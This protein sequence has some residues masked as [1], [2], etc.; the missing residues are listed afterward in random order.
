VP[1]Y[2]VH[3]NRLSAEMQ[4]FRNRPNCLVIVYHDF[5]KIGIQFI[6]ILGERGFDNA[7]LLTGGIEEFILTHGGL[8]DGKNIPK[9]ENKQPKGAGG[10]GDRAGGHGMVNGNGKVELYRQGQ[11]NKKSES[12]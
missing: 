6:N 9:C 4:E 12:K 10:K 3:Q 7:Y 11:F 8:V 2:L 1:G 5:E